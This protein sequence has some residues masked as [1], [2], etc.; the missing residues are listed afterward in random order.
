MAAI[1]ISPVPDRT[2]RQTKKERAERSANVF[3]ESL[4]HSPGLTSSMCAFVQRILPRL[5]ISRGL[6]VGG[7]DGGGSDR[8]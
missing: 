5:R 7:W 2:L 3:V 6:E 8:S 1:Y 4:E